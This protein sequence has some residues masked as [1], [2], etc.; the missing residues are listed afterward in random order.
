MKQGLHITKMTLPSS[1]CLST[2]VMTEI[3]D[4]IDN[5]LV[6]LVDSDSSCHEQ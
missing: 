1:T 2:D 4:F 6:L 3:D 5:Y